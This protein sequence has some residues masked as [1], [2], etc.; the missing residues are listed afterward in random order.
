MGRLTLY[1]QFLDCTVLGRFPEKLVAMLKKSGLAPVTE[2][3]PRTFAL[4]TVDFIGCNYYQPLRV[5]APIAPNDPITGPRDLF[6]AMIGRTKINPHR[7]W[8]IFPQ[9]I[10]DIAMRLKNSYGTIPWY[11]SENGMGFLKKNA[12]QRKRGD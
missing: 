5:Q 11:I 9:G 10:Y 6:E 1:S 3:G 12:S 2:E 4:N 7:G 8:E